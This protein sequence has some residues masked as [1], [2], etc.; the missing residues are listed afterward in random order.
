[1]GPTRGRAATPRVFRARR[2]LCDPDTWVEGGGL[3]VRGGR[4]E[5]VLRSSA[6]VARAGVARVVDLE[7]GVLT[8]G[9]VNAHAHLDLTGLAK[10]PTD[11]GFSAWVGAL[12]RARAQR[13]PGRLR[14]DA[15]EGARRMLATGTT[16]VG[17]V[18]ST[19]AGLA[20]ARD[21]RGPR[22]VIFREVLDAWD[23]ARTAPALAAVRR[24][25]RS[26][27]T[28]REGLSPHAPFTTSRDLLAGAAAI[29]HRRSLP[30][31]VHWSESVDELEYLRHGRGP[32]ASVLPPS[33]RTDGLDLLAQAG[34]LG[35]RTSL[36]HGNHPR[37]GE[38]DRIA[39]AGATLVHC[40]G[41]HAFFGREPFP[42][43]RYR[44]AGVPVALGTDSLASNADLD[45]RRELA[46]LRASCAVGPREAWRMATVHGARALGLEREVGV[47]RAGR[48]ADLVWYGTEAQGPGR[49]LDELTGGS[50]AVLG[51]WI[52]AREAREE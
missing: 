44:R 6:A 9:L 51:V 19:G 22:R 38:P 32:L 28:L 45:L 2:L 10:L 12:L 8:A 37:R 49:T 31:S 14:A 13:S 15:V 50:P 35:R 17:D 16:A 39:R 42:L 30:I 40:P 41:S 29:A 43:A 26:S 11:R 1:M 4:V 52:G 3:L 5:R 23:P 34:L 48:R 47:L 25:L 46:L 18:D 24:G 27:A 21:G 7:T 36:V 20:S 33:P